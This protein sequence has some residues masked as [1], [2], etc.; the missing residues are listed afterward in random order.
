MTNNC[1]SFYIDDQTI[2]FFDAIVWTIQ[3]NSD[4]SQA[5]AINLI[6]RFYEHYPKLWDD[7]WYEHEGFSQLICGIF[8]EELREGKYRDINFTE[9]REKFIP[10]QRDLV[11]SPNY[12]FGKIVD[13]LEFYPAD[14]DITIRI[15]FIERIR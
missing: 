5:Q 13:N 11:G 8:Y 12:R 10:E 1:Y 6:N 9:F 3:K 14:E 7:F 15:D 2:A 4:Y